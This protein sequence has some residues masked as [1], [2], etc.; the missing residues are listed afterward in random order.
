MKDSS[1]KKKKR[2]EKDKNV[3]H[4]FINENSIVDVDTQCMLNVNWSD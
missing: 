1:T 2:K 3:P 4:C